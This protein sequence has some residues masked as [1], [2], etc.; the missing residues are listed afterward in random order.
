MS[1]LMSIDRQLGTLLV[2]AA[3]EGHSGVITG[4]RG[5]LK[6][7]FCLFE[8]DVGYAISNVVEEQIEEHLARSGLL[9]PADMVAA[10]RESAKRGGAKLT[11]FLHDTGAIAA[12]RL[13][14]AI[15]DH[16]RELLFS[17]LDWTDGECTFERGRPDL[18]GEH[19]VRLN[20]P[21]LLLEYAR[22]RPKSVDAARMRIG[23]PNTQPVTSLNSEKLLTG[24]RPDAAAMY[25][26]AQSDGARSLGQLVNE[27]P[28]DPEI[29]W[30][31]IYGL[32]LA[33]LIVPRGARRED[34]SAAGTVSRDELLARLERAE[35]AS[36]YAVL[37]LSPTASSEEIREAYY[38]LARRYHPDRFRASNLEDLIARIESYFA[39]V[40]EAH[41]TLADAASRADYDGELTAEAGAKQPEQDTRDL[42]RQNYRLALTLIE[43]RRYTDA[44]TSLENAIQ[45]DG[46]QATYYLELGRLQAQ[47]PRH[48]DKAEQ[49]LIRSTEIDPALVDGYYSLGDLYAR[50]NRNEEAARLFREVLRWEPGHVMATEKLAEV[51]EP[52]GRDASGRRGLFGG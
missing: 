37:G 28:T 11:R 41:N 5:K 4:T 22:S 14:S 43:R 19:T 9:S 34:L 2:D 23:A 13:E 48:R 15:E 27:A 35:E 8:G 36:H 12:D 3:T 32:V 52:S 45:L 44:V 46:T 33:G 16:I 39:Q 49:N 7:L 29:T 47:N 25:V 30:R 40:T 6:R 26:L 17:T 21:T 42:A 10:H 24:V 18:A 1:G 38:F 31:S 20:A 51:G 50:T